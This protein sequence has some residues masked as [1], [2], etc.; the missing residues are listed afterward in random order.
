M[1]CLAVYWNTSSFLRKSLCLI[2]LQAELVDFFM[3]HNFY[4]QK[5]L[6]DILRLFRMECVAGI[7]SKMNLAYFFPKEN[8]KQYIL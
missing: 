7:S 3:E 4:L 6:A 2:E 1:A 8:N 5:W